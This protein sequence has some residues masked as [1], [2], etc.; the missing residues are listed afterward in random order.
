MFYAEICGGI[1]SGKTTFSKLLKR[2]GVNS[3]LEDFEINPF[4][5]KFYSNPAQYAFETEITFLLQHYHQIK[6][7]S[8]HEKAFACD[9]SLIL[10]LAYADVTLKSSKKESFLSVYSEVT[11]ELSDPDLVIHLVCDPKT[12]LERI[13]RRGRSVENTITTEFLRLLNTALEKRLSEVREKVNVVTI[14][15][16]KL[17]FANDDHAQQ[18]VLTLVQNSLLKLANPI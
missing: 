1:A 7:S 14:D 12:E 2:V 13:R 3:I 5:K 11:K 8:N 10:D 16:E 6:A 4:W 9:F 18:E 17:D 15:S